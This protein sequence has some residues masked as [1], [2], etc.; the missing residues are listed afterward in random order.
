[1]CIRVQLGGS[2]L[3]KPVL[4]QKQPQ[5]HAAG[6]EDAVEPS[7]Q[8]HMEAKDSSETQAQPTNK[9]FGAPL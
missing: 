3:A 8:W 9:L 1:M 7:P 6:Q 5:G 2:Y 4:T